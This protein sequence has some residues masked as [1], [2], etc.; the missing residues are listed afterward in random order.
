MKLEPRASNACNQQHCAGG[1]N[2]RDALKLMTLTAAGLPSFARARQSRNTAAEPFMIPAEQKL[3]PEWLRSLVMRDA[4][5]VWKGRV[6][7]FTK[8]GVTTPHGF[9][10]PPR[11]RKTWPENL[12][13]W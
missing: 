2:R 10:A 6:K 13:D 5:A 1:I 12:R 7:D 11:P 3:S 9:R 4:P 8:P